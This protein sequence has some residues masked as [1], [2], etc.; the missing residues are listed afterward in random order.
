M[1]FTLPTNTPIRSKP[2]PARLRARTAFGVLVTTFAL[3]ACVPTWSTS[4]RLTVTATGPTFVDLSWPAPVIDGDTSVSAYQVT[5]NGIAR[6][7]LPGTQR[8]VHIDALAAST[9]YKFSVRARDAKGQWSANVLTASAKTPAHPGL[10][11]G[12]RTVSVDVGGTT[13]T[14][15]LHV[16]PAVSAHPKTPV[17]LVVA[18]H[19]GLGNGTQ[20]ANTSQLDAEADRLGFVVAYPEGRLLTGAGGLTVRTW[21]GGGCCAAK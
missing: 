14:Y 21:N 19:G 8:A 7:T 13:R 11:A 1:G 5:V 2:V 18:L 20:L 16:P 9:S 17:A 10:A 6:P 4:D 15:V 12:T 3:A